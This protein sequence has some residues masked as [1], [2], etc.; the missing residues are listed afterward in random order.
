MTETFVMITDGLNL[1]PKSNIAATSFHIEINV[2]E[3]KTKLNI[4]A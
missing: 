1:R 2:N 3:L 4:D